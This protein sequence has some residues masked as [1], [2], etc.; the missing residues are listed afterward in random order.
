MRLGSG[1]DDHY[2][3]PAQRAQARVPYTSK[4]VERMDS[5]TGAFMKKPGNP[6]YPV[7][8]SMGPDLPVRL[9]STA[10]RGG[11]LS[12]NR[13]SN[14]ERMPDASLQNRLPDELELL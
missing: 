9:F 1:G 7:L 11:E 10:C 14:A 5:N 3:H 12:L 4:Y 6:R 13:Q 8:L 2:F